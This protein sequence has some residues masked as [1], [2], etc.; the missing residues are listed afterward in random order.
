MRTADGDAAEMVGSR[1]AAVSAEFEHALTREVMRTE[2]VRVKALIITALALI[3]ILAPLYFFDAEVV[4]RPD[5][6]LAR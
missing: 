5:G 3:V 6:M 2:L 1:A 4:Q